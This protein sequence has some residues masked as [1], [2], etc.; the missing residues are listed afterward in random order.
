MLLHFLVV[1]WAKELLKRARRDEMM[2]FLAI[3]TAFF[4]FAVFS[5][6][7]YITANED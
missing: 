3:F 2:M 1:L 5:Y 6:G 7:L 4:F